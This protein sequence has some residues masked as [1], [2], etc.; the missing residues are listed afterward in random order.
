VFVAY[1][2]NDRVQ[3]FDETGQ[4]LEALGG[5]GSEQGRFYRPQ[6][7]AVGA[8][9]HLFVADWKNHRIQKF[10]CDG[11]CTDCDPDGDGISNDGDGSGVAGDNPCREEEYFIGPPS[12]PPTDC[13]DN[14]P[15]V[16]N[17]DQVVCGDATTGIAC[18]SPLVTRDQLVSADYVS[19]D[20]N[21]RLGGLLEETNWKPSAAELEVPPVPFGLPEYQLVLIKAGTPESSLDDEPFARFS[22]C[23]DYYPLR[24]R[25]PPNAARPHRW[26]SPWKQ[27]AGAVA[28]DV[29]ASIHRG[30]RYWWTIR[31]RKGPKAPPSPIDHFESVYIMPRKAPDGVAEFQ[32]NPPPVDLVSSHSFGL[33]S[34]VNGAVCFSDYDGREVHDGIQYIRD[35]ETCRFDRLLSTPVREEPLSPGRWDSRRPRTKRSYANCTNGSCSVQRDEYE[36]MK[37]RADCRIPPD[38][39]AWEQIGALVSTLSCGAEVACLMGYLP[40]CIPAHASLFLRCSKLVDDILQYERGVAGDLEYCY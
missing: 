1:S 34:Q 6:G 13:D 17:S 7:V 30:A 4:F 20:I 27:A 3:R 38:D 37:L 10:Y 5:S 35:K 18:T 23:G 28:F 29:P 36:M 33:W 15:E 14:C 8:D 24:G 16:P 2:R 31:G 22:Q 32:P 26:F 25:L 9:G 11:T 21:P 12:P 40:T 19:V 39:S